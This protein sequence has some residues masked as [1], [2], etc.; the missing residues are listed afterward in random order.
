[1]KVG[2]WTYEGGRKLFAS[3]NRRSA[4]VTG[5]AYHVYA[6]R[7]MVFIQNGWHRELYSSRVSLI[8]G[9]LFLEVEYETG[10]TMA[11]FSLM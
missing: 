3:S 5:Q 1:M 4:A 7:G 11:T 10:Q 2:E 9:F 8:L 6:S